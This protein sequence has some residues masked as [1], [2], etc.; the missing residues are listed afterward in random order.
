MTAAANAIYENGLLRLLTP[1]PLP[2][3][4]AVRV[5]VETLPADAERTDWLEQGERKL[6]AVW[7]ND[8]DDVYNALLA[9]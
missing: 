2:E 3:H 4:T 6:L 7:D 9:E 5:Q 1:L 8:Q